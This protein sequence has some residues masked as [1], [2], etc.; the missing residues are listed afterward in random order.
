MFTFRHALTVAAL[1]ASSATTGFAD[2]KLEI[3]VQSRYSPLQFTD[4]APGGAHPIG[5][6]SLAFV[7]KANKALAP[8]GI[9]FLFHNSGKVNAYDE[10]NVLP[11]LIDRKK[12]GNL[13]GAVAEGEAGGGINAALSIPASSGLAFGEML[14]GGLPFGMAPDEYASFLYY[15]GGLVLQQQIYADAFDGKIITIPVAL[16]GAQGPGFFPEQLPDP[17]NNPDLSDADALAEFC[18]MPIIVR[19]PDSAAAVIKEACATVGV[20]T[21]LIGQ[22]T[23]CEDPKAVCDPAKN[24]DNKVINDPKVLTFGG[25][26]PGVIPHAMFSN[27]N[28]DAFELNMPGDDIQFLK[29]ATKQLDKTDAEADLNGVAP[30]YKYSG[31]WHQ[32]ILMVELVLNKAFWDGLS[33]AQQNLINAVAQATV[34]D[35]NAERMSLQGNAIARLETTGVTHLAW[36]NGLLQELRKAMPAAL[37]SLADEAAEKGDMSVRL[38]LDAAW[39]FQQKNAAFFDYGDIN[40]G[41][42]GFT[43]SE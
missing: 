17:D 32:P 39:A 24:P 9:E 29:L 22:E 7:L 5:G 3:K 33:S 30:P 37:N 35:I 18:N 8:L 41:Q 6:P 42:A 23:R 20:E 36:P 38:W 25:F 28:I 40:Q 13:Y 19:W 21:A 11:E 4:A 27:G 2:D 43:T 1:F 26:A 10:A 14:S 16:T 31:S 15:G 12:F 34:V